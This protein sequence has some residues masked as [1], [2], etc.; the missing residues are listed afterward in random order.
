MVQSGGQES[1]GNPACGAG[2]RGSIP[3]LRTASLLS[4]PSALHFWKVRLV[5]ATYKANQ[6][7]V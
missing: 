3:G 2:I 4:Y 6:V 7:H 1:T 5:W